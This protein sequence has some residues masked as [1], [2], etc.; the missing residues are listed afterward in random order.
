LD[1]PA[2]FRRAERETARS[3]RRVGHERENLER[4]RALHA[5]AALSPGQ[6]TERAAKEHR[7]RVVEVI[8]SD[9]TISTHCLACGHRGE[10]DPRV[11]A[12]LEGEATT[13]GAIE[14][15]LRCDR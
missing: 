15:R 7:P 12:V 5:Q 3:R 9:Q 13:M 6:L 10:L 2:A 8:A 11:L 14:R 4:L 1:R